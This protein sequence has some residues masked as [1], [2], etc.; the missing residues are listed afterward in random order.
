[1]RR[2]LKE[3]EE[4]QLITLLNLLNGVYI[5]EIGEHERVWN[6]VKDS[7]FSV[8]SFFFAISKNAR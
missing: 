8:S 1:M 2:N 7:L 6:A 5:L 3:K 4:S